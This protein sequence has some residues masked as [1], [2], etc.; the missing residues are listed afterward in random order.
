MH[1]LIEKRQADQDITDED[2]EQGVK[3]AVRTTQAARKQVSKVDETHNVALSIN[4]FRMYRLWKTKQV[5]A[6]SSSSVSSFI[7]Y[8]QKEVD[9]SIYSSD[10]AAN[11]SCK[12]MLAE[13]AV[14]Q[15]FGLMAVQA[16]LYFTLVC[17]TPPQA[18]L[19][20]YIYV[21][22]LTTP[23]M[24]KLYMEHLQ[25]SS[26]GSSLLMIKDA[27]KL[28]L[29]VDSVI[30]ASPC[31][32]Y[33][34]LFNHV[35]ADGTPK[36]TGPPPPPDK[37]STTAPAHFAYTEGVLMS[38]SFAQYRV[39]ELDR[40]TAALVDKDGH[41]LPDITEEVAKSIVFAQVETSPMSTV[42]T[43]VS[44]FPYFQQPMLK[45]VHSLIIFIC[46]SVVFVQAIP[47]SVQDLLRSCCKA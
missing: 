13:G 3:T 28:T 31:A 8:T 17:K 35:L 37:A 18:R 4:L 9:Q 36:A 42:S 7:S 5:K 12:N 14:C 45:Y 41:A 47:G 32:R 19:D 1:D 26:T 44:T 38:F 34:T 16:H 22:T 11:Q 27:G 40:A 20:C 30:I 23:K 2:I 21:S 33:L 43:I 15:L 46:F 10:R 25:K 29:C 39:Q 24:Q 6:N